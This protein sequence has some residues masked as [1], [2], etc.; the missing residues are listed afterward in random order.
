MRID[1]EYQRDG[2]AYSGKLSGVE[3]GGGFSISFFNYSFAKMLRA[4][5]LVLVEHQTADVVLG[6]LERP[7][8]MSYTLDEG[9]LDLL[10][11]DPVAAIKHFSPS[12][13][14]GTLPP[15]K[16]PST[17]PTLP[18]A[19]QFLRVG[20][21]TLADAFGE[22]VLL[23]Q[24]VGRVEC[25]K[26]GRYRAECGTGGCILCEVCGFVVPVRGLGQCTDAVEWVQVSVRCLL[27]AR[28]D[29]YFLPRAWNSTPPWIYYYDLRSKLEDYLR[30]KEQVEQQ[31]TEEIR[32]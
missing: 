31:L 19:P 23:R 3:E 17:D 2:E 25:P 12:F 15:P 4:L 30:N 32:T 16:R 24:R 20:S 29:R 18:S 1:L 7:G 8:L 21:E 27:A 28:L 10:R 5:H 14:R 22:L 11:R 9:T 6:R 26:C 13:E